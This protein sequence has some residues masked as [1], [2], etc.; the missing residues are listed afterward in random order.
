[1][2]QNEFERIKSYFAP[3]AESFA[4]ALSLKDDAAILS[5]EVGRELVVTTDTIVEGVHYIGDESPDFIARKLLRVSLSDLAAMGAEPFAYTLNIAL[6]YGTPDTWLEAFSNGLRA[7]QA[8]FGIH[9]AGGDSVSTPGPAVLTATLF[10]TVKTGGAV[11][12]TGALPGDIIFV[13]GT[14]GDATFGLSVA[15]QEIDADKLDNKVL[16][17]RYRLPQPRLHLGY[18]LKEAATAAAD[19]SDGL[20]ADL[21]HITEASACGA[22]IDLD[23]IPLSPAVRRLVDKDGDR[24]E[25][26][27]TGGDDYEIV[28]TARNQS[29]VA[30]ITDKLNLPITPIGRIVSGTAV[31][32]LNSRGEA[33]TFEEVGY[34]HV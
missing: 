32:I 18:C 14:I 13:S 11:R 7:D 31:E 5:M 20:L 1:M 2:P 9:L 17:A 4:G 33:I 26:V 10:G 30:D 8:E 3:L 24:W 12:R 25:K 29:C 28:F 22:V 6:P 19:I 15:R 34:K 23:N 21:G 27:L 16:E